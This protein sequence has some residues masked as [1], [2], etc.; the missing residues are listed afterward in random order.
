MTNKTRKQKAKEEASIAKDYIGKTEWP[1]A[2]SL[3]VW[4]VPQV[5]MEP[6][7]VPVRNVAQA[8]FVLKILADYDRFQFEKK[9]K[10]DYSNV[11]GLE[12][13]FAGGWQEWYDNDEHDIGTLMSEE[14]ARN[15]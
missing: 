1:V 11:A 3:R 7:H 4:H 13:Y 5:P 6:F 2:G 8:K 12:V 10:P 9:V 15:K 14:A